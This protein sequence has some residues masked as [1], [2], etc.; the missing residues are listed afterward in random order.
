MIPYAC[1]VLCF[2]DLAQARIATLGLNPSNVEFE[3]SGNELRGEKRRFPTLGSL[4]IADWSEARQE[5]LETILES[6]R[7][8][9][10]RHPYDKWFKPMENLIRRTAASYYS[11]DRDACHP[12]L[13]PYATAPVRSKLSPS[14]QS[15]LLDAA[16]ATLAELLRESPV[17][18]LVLNGRRVFKQFEILAE[19][20]LEHRSAVLSHTVNR[21]P[22]EFEELW[23]LCAAYR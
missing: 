17:Q 15:M 18:L 7:E 1:P 5:H 2:G 3:K 16:G 12:D 20:P 21:C 8:Y 14:S 22:R 9:F 19:I 11:P 6:C 10:L 13:V 23:I 4:G